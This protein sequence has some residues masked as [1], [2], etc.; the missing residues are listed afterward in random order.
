M[1]R[2]VSCQIFERATRKCGHSGRTIALADIHKDL[3]CGFCPNNARRNWL[4]RT[5]HDSKV[6]PQ[7][8]YELLET[9]TK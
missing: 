3:K 2:C 1:V 9:K 7:V 8:V 6:A 5:F 4:N